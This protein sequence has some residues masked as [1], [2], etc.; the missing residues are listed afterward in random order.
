MTRACQT[1]L[2][3]KRE[4]HESEFLGK[5]RGG[6]PGSV[7]DQEGFLRGVWPL[8]RLDEWCASYVGREGF[9]EAQ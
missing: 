9:E 1:C 6:P 3:W 5:C 4:G 7:V 2:W 8:T